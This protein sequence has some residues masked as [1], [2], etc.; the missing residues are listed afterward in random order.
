M[1]E[2]DTMSEQPRV[3]VWRRVLLGLGV[4][5]GLLLAAGVVMQMRDSSSARL[6]EI[7]AEL[8][9]SDPNW[10]LDDLVRNRGEVPDNQNSARVVMNAVRL[11][12]KEWGKVEVHL[13]EK[14]NDPDRLPPVRLDDEQ[15]ALL[16]KS[17]P[18]VAAALV[19]ARKLAGMPRGRH[20][21]TLTDNPLGTLLP[22]QQE[23]RRIASLLRYDVWVRAHKG[24]IDGALLSCRACLNAGRSLGDEPFIISQLIRIAC[25]A[26]ACNLA[27]RALALGEAS[28][29][30]LAALQHLLAQEARDPAMLAALRG[31]RAI[32]DDLFRKMEDGTIKTQ[33]LFGRR[34]EDLPRDVS[35]RVR[36]LGFSKGDIRRNRLLALEMMNQ[37]ID[38]ARLPSHEQ[39]ARNRA[40]DAQIKALPTDAVLV[41]AL[42]PAISKVAEADRRKAADVCTLG[43]LLA[44]E[45]Y[46]LKKG[47]WPA[48]L[49]ELKPDFLTA[50]PLDPFDGKPLRYVKR[51]DGVTVYS[52]GHDGTDDGGKIDRSKPLGPGVDQGY[53]LWDVKFRRQAPVPKPVPPAG[54]PPGGP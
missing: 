18:Q 7:L 5:I 2:L 1:S 48:N 12:P 46:R 26:I 25:V 10:R 13:D 27:E 47:K 4:L 19:E 33:D 39:V 29:A 44:V 23:T 11:T 51:P 15:L 20:R 22:D 35:W 16:E 32:V 28:D 6:R 9:Q 17:L 24:D 43:A 3:S 49:E 36:L 34:S 40:L 38:T 21:L 42:I 31:E 54:P 50:V 41:R 52:V 37:I 53:R 30:E 8:D 14:L 45:R